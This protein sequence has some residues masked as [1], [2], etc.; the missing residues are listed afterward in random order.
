MSTA[1][2][3]CQ[4][5]FID[6][7]IQKLYKLDCIVTVVDA[8][9]ILERLHEGKPPGVE[10]EAVE[11]VCFSD[12]ILLNKV[13]LVS[14]HNDGGAQHFARIEHK[15]RTLNPTASIQHTTHGNIAPHRT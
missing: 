5:F 7:D 14:S 3:V 11:Q 10:N 9:H 6:K 1:V 8:Q 2:L 12:K 15:L 13:D 4:T